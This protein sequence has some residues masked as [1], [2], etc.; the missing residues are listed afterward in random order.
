MS[1]RPQSLAEVAQRGADLRNFG[2]EFQDWLHTVRGIRSRAA[3]QR[4]I[5]EEPAILSKRSTRISWR[6]SAR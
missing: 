5:A 3:L 2:W 1:P 4:T 6:N